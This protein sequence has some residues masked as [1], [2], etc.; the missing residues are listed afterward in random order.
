[1]PLNRKK[2]WPTALTAVAVGLASLTLTATTST[3]ADPSSAQ[4]HPAGPK[5]T[6]VLVHGAWADGSSWASVTRR[7]QEK[8]Y[9]VDVVPNPLRG[10]KS[11]SDYLR[12]YLAT[13]KGPIVLAAHSYGGM[14]IT[15]AATGNANVKALVYVD[16]YIPETGDALGPLSGKDSALA[17]DPT[18]V[19]DAVTGTDG[20]VDLY[21]K[22]ALFPGIFVKGV[23]KHKAAVLAAS[24]RPL[25][26]TALSEP[27]TGTPAWKT[28]PSWDVVGTADRVIPRSRQ[29]FM[30]HRA[31]ARIT[32]VDAPHLSMVS[33]PRVVTKVIVSAANHR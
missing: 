3:A 32:K 5:P 33:D 25:A 23:P 13:V 31:H 29:E 16:A 27:S 22:Q 28:I 21:V 8:G 2:H 26:K 14:I 18:T 11:D 20:T 30:A 6:V 15:Q 1:V 9:T 12:D 7:L 17:V 24:Q 19:F 10:V 4:H